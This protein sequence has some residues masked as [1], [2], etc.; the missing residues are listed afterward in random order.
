MCSQSSLWFA[1]RSEEQ[2]S[3]CPSTGVLPSRLAWPHCESLS[4][5]VVFIP[6]ISLLFLLLWT[7]LCVQLTEFEPRQKAHFNFIISVWFRAQKK[8]HWNSHKKGYSSQGIH[9]LWELFS[10]ACFSFF[11]I[12]SLSFW[13]I[14][15]AAIDTRPTC[16]I[17]YTISVF[18]SLF[19]LHSSP[20][21]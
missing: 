5:S 13:H 21:Y 7:F 17:F 18:I 10:M 20:S 11:Y 2:F 9:W 19:A 12:F 4:P 14:F 3:Q 16:H 8:I 1:T 15:K 6:L